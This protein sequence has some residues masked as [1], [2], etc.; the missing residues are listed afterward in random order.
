MCNVSVVDFFVRHCTVDEFDG[1]RVLEIGSKCINGSVRSFIEHFLHPGEYLG[2]DI[3][4][5]QNVDRVVPAETLAEEFGEESFDI[6]VSTEVLEHIRDW[7]VVVEN[8]KRVLRPGGTV[9]LTTRSKGFFYHGYPYDFWRYEVAD[10]EMIFGDFEV[11]AAEED[12]SCPGAFIKAR[13]PLDYT[14]AVDLSTMTMY[15]VVV[16]KKVDYLPEVEEM[17]WLKKALIRAS[18]TPVWGV[19]PWHIKTLTA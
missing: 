7:R 5:G 18:K 13:K 17:P 6:V 12:P 15:S 10:L 2:T 9:F 3:E 14:Q 19:I 1:K 16:G 8:V 11:M 4:E